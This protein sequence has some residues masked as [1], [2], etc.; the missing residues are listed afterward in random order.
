[1]ADTSPDGVCVTEEVFNQLVSVYLVMRPELLRFLQAQLGNAAA[2]DDVFQELFL[3]LRLA[4]LSAEVQN[5]RSF[6]FRTAFNLAN[7]YARGA[8]RATRHGRMRAPGRCADLLP[9]RQ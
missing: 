7:E 2:A 4:Q 1:M 3:R 5:P 9:A 8:W 6:M